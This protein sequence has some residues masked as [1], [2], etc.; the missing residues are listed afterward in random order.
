MLCLPA[1]VGTCLMSLTDSVVIVSS[2]SQRPALDAPEGT[3]DRM[4]GSLSR[5]AGKSIDAWPA[6]A[7]V[8]WAAVQVFSDAPRCRGEASCGADPQ[9]VKGHRADGVCEKSAVLAVRLVPL[10][11]RVH[12][13]EEQPGGGAGVHVAPDIAL[14]LGFL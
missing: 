2:P 4:I 8:A 6:F 13:A 1:A 3:P 5:R 7:D 10:H 14:G 11:D 12:H 9:P